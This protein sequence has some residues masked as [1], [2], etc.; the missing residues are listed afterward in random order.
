LAGLCYGLDGVP[1]Q[2][3]DSLARKIEIDAIIEHFVAAA[4]QRR[5]GKPS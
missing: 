2:W 4:S 3:L 1:R 5:A